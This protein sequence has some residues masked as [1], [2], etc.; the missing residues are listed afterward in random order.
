MLHQIV[1]DS[2]WGS[3]AYVVS[4]RK[5]FK[6]REE[7]YT[8]VE[9]QRFKNKVELEGQD[10]PEPGANRQF[11]GGVSHLPDSTASSEEKTLTGDDLI[12]INWEGNNDPDNPHNWPLYYKVIFV[13]K[14]IALTALIYMAAALYTPSLT[15]VMQ[16]MKVS[17]VK[18]TLPLTF[19]AI[20]YGIGPMI[21]SPLSENARFGRNTIY[22][23]T[24]FI[25]FILQIPTALVTD[26]ASL[27]VL[28]FLAGFFASPVL[29]TGG[30]SIGDVISPEYMPMAL[31]AWT[32]G[33]FCAPSVGP[34]IGAA[35]T[36]AGGYHWPF[37]FIFIESGVLFLILSFFLP[38]S[39]GK[40]I[41]YRKAKRLRKITG[42][43]HITSIGHI[44]NEEQNLKDVILECLWRPIQITI[45]EPVILFFDL[46]MGIIYAIMY[47]WYMAFPIVFINMYKFS[48]VGEGASSLSLTVGLIVSVLFHT[49]L[50]YHKTTRKLLD[51][52][53]IHPEVYLPMCIFGSCLLPTGLIIFAWTSTKSVHWIAPM[54][55]AGTYMCGSYIVFQ[56]LFNYMGMSFPRYLASVYAGNG[57]LRSIMGGAFAL[58]GTPMFT[59][60]STT[61]YPVAWGTMILAFITMALISVPVLFYLNGPK[62][63]AKSKY[64]D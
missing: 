44:Q 27:T 34:L 48:T 13:I 29:A 40:A 5:L 8:F 60:L 41:L 43:K 32:A 18:A 2:F 4:N 57:L 42:N 39:S 45:R 16:E 55:G 28:R 31:S 36:V 7:D 46:Y 47:L 56:T 38:E 3:I 30:A 12:Y 53:D 19:F 17:R 52:K 14:I 21:F 15:V 23:V 59:N 22:I 54:V 62:L 10:V 35:L 63:R 50:V 51:G 6:Y 26:I 24:L 1:R 64:A 11:L 37:W 25:F 20:G 61:K 9:L 49:P 33:T 58:F